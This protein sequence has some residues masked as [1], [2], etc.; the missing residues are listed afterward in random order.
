MVW[1]LAPFA[2][3]Q[4][5]TQ[6]ALPARSEHPFELRGAD[7]AQRDQ[8]REKSNALPKPSVVLNGVAPVGPL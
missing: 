1:E 3:P 6:Q 5:E 7:H 8:A 4:R 2:G